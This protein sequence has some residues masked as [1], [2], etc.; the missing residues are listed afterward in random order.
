MPVELRAFQPTDIQLLEQWASDIGIDEFM[1][2]YKQRRA[3]GSSHDPG[4]GLL[5]F[6]IVN[7]GIDAGTVWLEPGEQP[8]ESILG[9]FLGDRSAFG[10]GIGSQA[11]RLAVSQL[12][13]LCPSQHVNLNVRQSNS[14]AIACYQKNG[15]SITSNGIKISPSGDPIPFFQMQLQSCTSIA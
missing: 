4:N 7:S 6:V 15:F 1:S 3:T 9:I 10:R 14:R 12:W 8:N 11:I 2:R 5:W 13:A